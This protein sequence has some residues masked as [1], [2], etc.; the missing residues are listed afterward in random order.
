MVLSALLCLQQA[1]TSVIPATDGSRPIGKAVEISHADSV[2]RLNNIAGST[3]SNSPS[4]TNGAAKA[5]L[6]RREDPPELGNLDQLAKWLT[7]TPVRADCVFVTVAHLLGT[8]PEEVSRRT[9]VPIPQP[10]QGGT[11]EMLTILTKLGLV[12]RVWTYGSL[13]QGGGGP[14]RTRPLHPGRPLYVA[15]PRATGMPRTMGVAYYLPDATGNIRPDGNGEVIGHVVV[16]TNPGTPYARYIDYQADPNGRDITETMRNTRIAAY[17]SIDPNASTGDFITTQRPAMEQM[18]VEQEQA[19]PETQSDGPQ[20]EAPD[21]SEPME[22]DEEHINQWS[23]GQFNG[24]SCAAVIAAISAFS[25]HPRP[26]RSLPDVVLVARDKEST[27]SDCDR[28]RDM[29][30]QLQ[31]PQTS[32]SDES[33]KDDELKKLENGDFS[34]FS[35]RDCALALE[36]MYNKYKIHTPELGNKLGRRADT[37]EDPKADCRRAQDLVQKQKVPE[38][39]KKIKNI[40]IGFTLSSSWLSIKGEGTKDDVGAILEGPAGKAELLLASQP[41]GGDSKWITLDMQKSFKAD[42]IDITGIN[43]LT[44]TAETFFVRGGESD[45]F[46]VQDLR[47]RA[48][49]A[50]PGFGAKN[51]KYVGINA[52]YER[53][54]KGWW[55]F[56]T[57]FYPSNYDKKN[58][59][60]FPVVPADWEFAPPCAS[61]KELS[62]DFAFGNTNGGGTGDTLVLKLG[63]GKIPLGKSFTAGTSTKGTVDLKKTFKKKVVQLSELE[64]VAFDDDDSTASFLDNGWT[65]KGVTFTATC[66]DVPKK[67]QMNKY[68]NVNADIYAAGNKEPWSGKLIPSDWI[69]IK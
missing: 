57:V 18:E 17:F 21:T 56:S 64:T 42:S 7:N 50:D 9:N 30:T 63:Q 11:P 12:F 31:R 48:K 16:C 8:T 4:T 10:G 46:K 24:A 23:N 20:V 51:D 1:S 15:F 49:C 33:L 34:G 25:K 26:G 36:K 35:A 32:K 45:A 13:P 37:A 54:Q 22:V 52:W 61:F 58:L 40:E 69:E 38:P 29:A 3:V 5:N 60:T 66:A 41:S 6:M 39:C 47:L 19:H 2:P 28:A 44:L 14:I 43:N 62:Y 65:F 27:S 59:A 67:L 68:S 53:P 55:I